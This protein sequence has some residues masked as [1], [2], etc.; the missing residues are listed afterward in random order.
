MPLAFGGVAPIP[1]KSRNCC[2]HALVYSNVYTNVK[3]LVLI[4]L[5]G[6]TNIKATATHH[7][8]YQIADN[9]HLL[10]GE[11]IELAIEALGRSGQT[12]GQTAY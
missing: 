8:L 4:T 5:T 6:Q 9:R 3:R 12:Q 7:R 1:V 11:I 10:L 2:G